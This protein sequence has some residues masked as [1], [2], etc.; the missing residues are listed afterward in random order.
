MTEKRIDQGKRRFFR[1]ERIFRVRR[2]QQNREHRQ[3][4]VL[5]NGQ[6]W[7]LS[8][9][10]MGLGE[11][12]A[13]DLKNFEHNRRKAAEEAALEV[14]EKANFNYTPQ[15]QEKYWKIYW[16]TWSEFKL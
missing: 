12:L 9:V 3:V 4:P 16:K 15:V 7:Y 13:R 1:R 10:V 2:A 11:R 8:R 14:V 5:R 6:R